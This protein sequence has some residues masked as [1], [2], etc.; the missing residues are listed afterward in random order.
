MKI[1]KIV[2]LL[3]CLFNLSGCMTSFMWEKGEPTYSQTSDIVD[4][5]LVAK[6]G[7]QL[8]VVSEKYHYVFKISDDL[9]SILLSEQRK[10]IRPIFSSFELDHN[11]IIK[12]NYVLNYENKNDPS[13]NPDKTILIGNTNFKFGRYYGYLVGIRYSSK[14]PIPTEYKF[15]RPYKISII[16]EDST[17]STTVAKVLATPFTLA[18]DTVM[19]FMLGL[20]SMDNCSNN[21]FC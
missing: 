14:E 5:F 17:D 16:E 11:N 7:Q 10:Y 13:S 15:N 8:I 2:T 6:D 21:S 9:R 1:V 12:G 20:V 19:F 3:F 4:S 18:A